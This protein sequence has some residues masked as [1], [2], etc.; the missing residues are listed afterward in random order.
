V[1]D[2]YALRAS[3]IDPA[4]R[5]NRGAGQQFAGRAEDVLVTVDAGGGEGLAEAVLPPGI[6]M[7]TSRTPI[8]QQADMRSSA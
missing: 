6:P 2:L 3:E 7:C 1:A 4:G 8:E 5:G